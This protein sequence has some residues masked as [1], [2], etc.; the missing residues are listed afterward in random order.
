MATQ[1]QKITTRL[2]SL[3][4]APSLPEL[5]SICSQKATRDQYP[6]ASSI[7]K[8][9]P[10]YT[11]AS[12]N[13]LQPPQRAAL[14]DEWY[15]ILHSG[16]GVFVTKGLFQSSQIPVIDRATK[17]FYSI[18]DSERSSL[19]G[20]HFAAA[21]K[22]DRIWNSFSKHALCDPSSFVA[23]YSNPYIA[24][25]ASAWL[26]PDYRVT[27]QANNVRPGSAAQ[28][29]HRDYHL[30]FQTAEACARIPTAMHITSQF[31]TL[32]G[33][34]AHVDIPL[35][36]GPTRLLPFSQ[37]FEPGFMT[38]RRPEFVDFFHESYVALPMDKGDGI[39]F[40]PALFH[41]AGE[42]VSADIER[43]ANLL[44]ISSAFG[45]T[46]ETV[47][48]LPILESCWEEIMATY[49]T[50]AVGGG[51]REELLVLLA[52]ICTVYPFPTN[53]DNNP[54]RPG[55][56]TPMGELDIVTAAL[57]EGWSK[58]RMLEEVKGLRQRSR[59]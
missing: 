15:H 38:Y 48:A 30:G 57:M 39:F 55:G 42:N 45:K 9:V 16:P 23:Y 28:V 47:E 27:A 10:V 21:G 58:E 14:Q 12:Y 4:D 24:L 46:M 3:H 59:P 36:S 20:D 37:T 7:D 29:P 34:V 50:E 11:L 32:Q 49:D 35:E 25:I 6:L 41:A 5:A 1:A 56:L 8:N 17:A 2:F 53:M 54:P 44:Q 31:L 19:R 40:N 51:L 26:G 52:T 18:I 22:N 33:A 13:S 43:M